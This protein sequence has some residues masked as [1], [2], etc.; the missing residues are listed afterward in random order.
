MEESIELTWYEAKLA[1]EV[2]VNRCLSS[3]AKGSEHA[4]AQNLQEM[5]DELTPS[6]ADPTEIA[7]LVRRNEDLARQVEA[8]QLAVQGGR[9]GIFEEESGGLQETAAALPL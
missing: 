3:W 4:H 5:Y 2:G 6:P 7:E 9:Q 8:L 1:T